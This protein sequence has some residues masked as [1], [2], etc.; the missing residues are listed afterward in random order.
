MNLIF[1]VGKIKNKSKAWN[2][3]MGGGEE[4]LSLTHVLIKLPL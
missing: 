4:K 1:K 3:D 2:I